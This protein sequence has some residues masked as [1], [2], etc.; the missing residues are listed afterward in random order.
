[1]AVDAAFFRAI[2][3]DSPEPFEAASDWIVDV[4]TP[5]HSNGRV[6]G[7]RCY[8]VNVDS[9]DPWGG[10]WNFNDVTGAGAESGWRARGIP[11][12]VD[13]AISLRLAPIALGQELSLVVA[14]LACAVFLATRPSR[15]RIREVANTLAGLLLVVAPTTPLVEFVRVRPWLNLAGETLSAWRVHG[16]IA[17]AALIA[18]CA[19]RLQARSVESVA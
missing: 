18:L 2:E 11:V 5:V 17:I 12:R 6:I 1:L 3:P 14:G 8:R 9:A 4:D 15:G 7:T 16:T 19:V 10:T 13:L